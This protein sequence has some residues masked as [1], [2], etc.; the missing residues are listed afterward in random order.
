M[1]IY[2]KSSTLT[3]SNDRSSILC[4][5]W[6]VQCGGSIVIKIHLAHLKM[7][8][9]PI[10]RIICISY[11]TVLWCLLL[12]GDKFYT[13]NHDVLNLMHPN[14][15]IYCNIRFISRMHCCMLIL[16][17]WCGNRKKN[18]MTCSSGLKLLC[19]NVIILLQWLISVWYMY[20]PGVYDWNKVSVFV[21]VNM[22]KE[23][24]ITHKC[25]NTVINLSK[26][27]N[28]FTRNYM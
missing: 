18:V 15:F 5:F 13:V 12:T 9:V 26:K 21:S 7:F 16:Y 22:Y 8:Y 23:A 19:Y 2:S 24:A 20:A 27:I 1:E 10:Y 17:L 4:P 11:S 3:A 25:V 28:S 6:T 14:T